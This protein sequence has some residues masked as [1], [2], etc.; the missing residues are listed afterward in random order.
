[1]K[2]T[3]TSTAIAA[4]LTLTGI[5]AHASCTDPRVPAQQGVSQQM[6]PLFRQGAVAG[7]DSDKARA[8]DRIVGTWL[9][10]Y[11]GALAGEAFIQWHSDGTEWENIDYPILGGTIC[12]GDW[13]AIGDRHVRRSHV[14]WLYTNGNPSG[15][16]TETETDEVAR[17]GTSYTGI[18]DAKFYDVDGN[19][20]AEA[21]G[22]AVAKRIAPP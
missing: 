16:F 11:T 14:G 18:N 2:Y 13:K 9:V 21:T 12:M 17:D 7:S 20:F 10:T 19:M 5:S 15:F 1:M 22:T 8:G 6:A 4:A 3:L